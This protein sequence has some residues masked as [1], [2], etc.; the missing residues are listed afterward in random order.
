MQNFINPFSKPLLPV[1]VHLHWDNCPQKSFFASLGRREPKLPWFLARATCN[2]V[3]ARR[4]WA[5]SLEPG[6]A[7]LT[8]V[9]FAVGTETPWCYSGLPKT[10]RLQHP[11][12]REGRVRV[13]SQVEPEGLCWGKDHWLHLLWER[14]CA[15]NGTNTAFPPPQ[16]FTELGN[17]P[18][19]LHSGSQ[20]SQRQGTVLHTEAEPALG[21]WPP[22]GPKAAAR[23]G[24]RVSRLPAASGWKAAVRSCTNSY[25]TVF[26]T[27]K[28]F[29]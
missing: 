3:P 6:R 22:T 29:Q 24:N 18:S 7:A 17:L 4:S 2:G 16:L 15:E 11:G 20:G 10:P 13:A 25:I 14:I 12:Q 26:L 27:C 1:S 19:G 28:S 9:S 23:F 21:L 8:T 5:V